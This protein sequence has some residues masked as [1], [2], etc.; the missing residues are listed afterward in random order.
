MRTTCFNIKEAVRKSPLYLLFLCALIVSAGALHAQS[1]NGRIVGVVKDTTGALISG[2]KVVLTEESTG[3]ERELATQSDGSYAFNEIAPSTYRIVVSHDGFATHVQTGIVVETNQSVRMD[4]SLAVGKVSEE[5]VVN[6]DATQ[7][8]N[9]DTAAKGEVITQR[10]VEELPLN[11]RDYN[12]L[13][14]LVPGVFTRPSSTDQ[15]QG[16]SSNGTRTDSSQVN[17]DGSS[18]RTERQGGTGFTSSLD[19]IKEFKV[20][21]SMYSAEYGRV[22]GAQVNIVTKSGTNKITGTLFEYLRNNV[23]DA[24][25]FLDQPD[26]PVSHQL[27]RNQFGGTVGGPIAKNKAFYFLSYEGVRQVRGEYQKF[28]APNADW[29][30]RGASH[31]IGDFRNIGVGGSQVQSPAGSSCPVIGDNPPTGTP[32]PGPDIN[33]A[34]QLLCP[35]YVGYRTGSGQARWKNFSTPNVIDASMIS[36]VARAILPYLPASNVAGSIDSYLANGKALDT[37]DR[38][39]AKLDYQANARNHFYIRY[40]MNTDFPLEP[41]FTGGD[42]YEQWP[43]QGN[44][45]AHAA[46]FDHTFIVTPTIVND[47]NIGFLQTF[48]SSYPTDNGRN[49]AAEFG[50]AGVNPPAKMSGFPTINMDGFPIAGNEGNDPFQYRTKTLQV[51]D[52]VTVQRRHHT[53]KF[54]GAI[55]NSNYHEPDLSY[56]RG[57]FRFRGEW[58]NPAATNGAEW[59]S[60]ADFLLGELN[61]TQIQNNV[62]YGAMT[63]TTYSV[64]L[65]DDWKVLPNLT[66]NAGIRYDLA[67]PYHEA[68]DRFANFNRDT[69]VVDVACQN[70]VSC[71]IKNP[72]YRNIQPRFG[73]AW[74]PFNT[75]TTVLR[76]GGGIFFTQETL[77]AARQQ[78]I[79]NAPFVD[80]K[81]YS[82]TTSDPTALTF[83]NPFPSA[84]VRQQLAYG[85]QTA[86]HTPVVYQY[87]LTLERQFFPDTVGEFSYVGSNSKHLGRR[88]N[89][90]QGTPI[91]VSSSGTVQ[92]TY[93]FNANFGTNSIQYQEQEANANFN[94]LQVSGRRRSRNGLTMLVSY[95][96]SR[97]ID[98][99]SN[100]NNSTSG[101]Q[102]FAQNIYNLRAERGL[103]DYHRAHQFR[104]AVNYALP[105]GKGH[106]FAGKRGSLANSLASGWT[107]NG[108]ITHLSSRPFTPQYLSPDVSS[109]RPNLVGDPNKAGNIGSC[110]GPVAIGGLGQPWFNP[111]AFQTPKATVD[112]GYSL[113]GNLPRNTLRGPNFDDTDLGITRRFNFAKRYKLDFRAEVFNIF[114][115]PNLD[116][117]VYYL[118]Q[119]NVGQF[120]ATVPVG[121]SNA[122]GPNRELQLALRLSF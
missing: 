99:G 59:F 26:L 31:T 47:L 84:N 118:D 65:Q 104:G 16:V 62:V 15:G 11:G 21:T 113:Y 2:S 112:N 116:L 110:V 37:A 41:L 102:K 111:C 57:R 83:A 55:F 64:Y 8:I 18:I 5:V 114:N 97:A 38:Y 70:G 93:P 87:N 86:T 54:G 120:T 72:D 95:T 103:A 28:L 17:L 25:N 78:L 42:H 96:F 88:I 51:S 56:I 106:R 82:R 75:Q 44:S 13:L 23:L 101:T 48:S 89:A 29:L 34:G 45:R 10:Q 68:Q 94:S 14:T 22:A 69:G 71:S 33:A 121:N 49:Y 79:D 92:Y 109:Q 30:G 27:R 20:V 39:L 91:G 100:T 53:I 7:T 50:I 107:I 46:T 108:V 85:I 32:T 52:S 77:N 76:G 90:N 66:F 36:P 40:S 9:T 35:Q 6:T 43:R 3:L 60:F 122:S 24:K 12:D 67:M 105:F 74:L 58:T 1:A 80:R 19:S 4:V 115:H 119:S 117:P 73:F 98:D 63:A 81:Q 61:T